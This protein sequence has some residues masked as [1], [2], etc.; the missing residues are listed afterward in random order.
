MTRTEA[1]S[2]LPWGLNRPLKRSLSDLICA[3]RCLGRLAGAS[4]AGI[5]RK[6]TPSIFLGWVVAPGHSTRNGDEPT[7]AK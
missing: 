3:L 7:D 2:S 6:L 5:G 4:V 1:V